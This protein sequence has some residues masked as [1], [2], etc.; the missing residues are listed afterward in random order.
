MNQHLWFEIPGLGIFTGS[1]S[2][3]YINHIQQLIYPS[4]IELEFVSANTLRTETMIKNLV[5]ETGFEQDILEEHLAALCQTISESLRRNQFYDFIPFG[6]LGSQNGNI[7]FTQSQNNI[8]QEF[9]W[10]EPL[11]IMPLE[12]QAIQEFTPVPA[13]VVQKPVSKSKKELAFLIIALGILWLV[14]LGLLCCPRGSGN[15]YADNANKHS[16][17]MHS[18]NAV[19]PS[20]HNPDTG[21]I[22][23]SLVQTKDTVRIRQSDTST[24]LKN[25]IVVDSANVKEL[26]D[27]IKYKP[28]IIIVGSFV[29]LSNAEKLSLKVKSDGYEVYRGEYGK[30]HRVG[31]QFNCFKHDLQSM[32]EEL[33]KKYHPDSWVLKY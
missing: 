9:Y 23:D 13:A 30:F 12:N 25:E 31:I 3:S 10:M 16:D 32:V 19:S 18:L 8:H 17:T 15:H 21:R 11:S 24:Q 26:N 28:C 5:N 7:V 22:N 14:F 29:K 33:K 6:T 2:E 20:N 27:Q 1:K 4:R